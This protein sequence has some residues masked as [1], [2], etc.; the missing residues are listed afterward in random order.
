MCVFAAII[1]EPVDVKV[2]LIK[3][4][5]EARRNQ[6]IGHQITATTDLYR[7][8]EGK[9]SE[10]GGGGRRTSNSSDTTDSSTNQ[11]TKTNESNNNDRG[12]GIN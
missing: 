12:A 8:V 11:Q 1:T 9:G 2:K 10:G 4:R 3:M 6:F 5:M 7:E